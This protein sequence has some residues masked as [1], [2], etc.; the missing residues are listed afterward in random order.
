MRTIVKTGI[1]LQLD[2]ASIED[3]MHLQRCD[4]MPMAVDE[5]NIFTMYGDMHVVGQCSVLYLPNHQ[6]TWPKIHGTIS[7]KGK[8]FYRPQDD[9]PHSILVVE[10]QR[11]AIDRDALHE[12]DL[13]IFVRAGGRV[14]V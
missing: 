6:V 12:F 9:P 11:I 1:V 4:R 2:G 10:S 5:G 8:Y 3:F 13:D 14:R 7:L